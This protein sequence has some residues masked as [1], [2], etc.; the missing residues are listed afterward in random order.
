MHRWLALLALLYGLLGLWA[1]LSPR[2]QNGR[3]PQPPG[4]QHERFQPGRAGNEM[5]EAPAPHRDGG[6]PPRDE[7]RRR[8]RELRREDRHREAQPGLEQ[9][10]PAPPA[11]GGSGR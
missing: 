9:R 3:P 11:E 7:E 6:P 2:P 5:R 8:R 4:G 10:D 1:M